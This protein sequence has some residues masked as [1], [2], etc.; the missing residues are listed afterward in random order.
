MK[1]AIECL[2][3]IYVVMGFYYFYNRLWW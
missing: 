3:G 1:N 2:D